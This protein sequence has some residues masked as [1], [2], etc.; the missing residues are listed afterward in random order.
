[1][2]LEIDVLIRV[3]D[4]AIMRK[5]HACGCFEWEVVR[6]GADIGVRCA[7]CGRRVLLEREYFE[8]RVKTLQP[9]D[10]RVEGE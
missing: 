9:K 1:M 4:R 3:G 8:R 6:T 5:P 7:G 2:A 10:D